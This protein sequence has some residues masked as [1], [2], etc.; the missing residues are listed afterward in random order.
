MTIH[1]TPQYTIGHIRTMPLLEQKLNLHAYGSKQCT[2]HK[3]P[4]FLHISLGRETIKL[5]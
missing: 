5:L 2:T 4:T 3:L 1:S